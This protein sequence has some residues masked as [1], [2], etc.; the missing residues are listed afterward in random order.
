MAFNI[1]FFQGALK[2][3]GARPSLF[4]VNITNPVDVI[5]DIQVPFLCKAAAIPASSITPIPVRYFGREIKLA[6]TR[7][8][9]EW[10]VT[11]INDEDFAI[12]NALEKWSA[13]INTHEGNLRDFGSG[14]PVLYKSD[15]QVTQFAKTGLP[16]RVYNFV[17]IFPTEIGQID[18]NWDSG[19]QI[20]EYPVTFQYDYW[21]VSGGITGDGG[22][23]R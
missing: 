5:S 6:G 10:T 21:N 15:A 7:T 17:G 22:T 3:G 14:S 20:E 1:N 11:V 4:Q 19:D 18:L 23:T 12:R 8:F 9:P 13:S 2:F 16:L